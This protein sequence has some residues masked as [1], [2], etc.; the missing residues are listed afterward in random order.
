M[1]YFSCVAHIRLRMQQD[2]CMDVC[3]QAR[4]FRCMRM[5]VMHAAGSAGEAHITSNRSLKSYGH[6]SLRD[7]VDCPDIH[8]KENLCGHKAE[9]LTLKQIHATLFLVRSLFMAPPDFA[10]CQYPCF[11]L[12][13]RVLSCCLARG[14]CET[15]P[16]Q[17]A[18]DCHEHRAG[19]AQMA[20]TA[21]HPAFESWK[22]DVGL[23]SGTEGIERNCLSEHQ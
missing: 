18:H 14:L 3:I 23:G 9:S 7:F 22:A 5:Y 6:R 17:S 4:K 19:A 13:S 21:Q 20:P 2:A 10:L 12:S 16:V 1:W 8:R 15:E 11:E